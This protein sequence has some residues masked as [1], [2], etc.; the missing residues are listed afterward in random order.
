MSRPAALTVPPPAAHCGLL[1]IL[2]SSQTEVVRRLQFLRE[3]LQLEQEPGK[4][5]HKEPRLLVVPEGMLTENVRCGGGRGS[6][7]TQHSPAGRA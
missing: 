3:H 2:L 5:L 7:L 4:L 1:Q 6:P